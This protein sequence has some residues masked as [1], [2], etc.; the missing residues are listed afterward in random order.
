MAE[1]FLLRTEDC[2][3]CGGSGESFEVARVSGEYLDA[4]LCSER[5]PYCDGSGEQDAHCIECGKYEA[6]NDDG[7]CAQCHDA[8]VLD[9]DDFNEKWGLTVCLPDPLRRV[10]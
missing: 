2:A 4:D 3:E 6:L 10:A 1:S 5:C 8:S 9:L 7:E